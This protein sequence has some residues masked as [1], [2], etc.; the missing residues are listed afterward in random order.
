MESSEEKDLQMDGS[1]SVSDSTRQ[2]SL[3]EKGLAYQVSLCIDG[4]KSSRKAWQK[5][6]DYIAVKLSDISDA[7]LL[8]EL[9][10]TLTI[11]YDKFL[12]SFKKFESL[13]FDEK[14]LI[15]EE[16]QLV[17]E[18]Q[19][20]IEEKVKRKLLQLQNDDDDGESVKSEHSRVSR[21][22]ANSKESKMSLSKIMDA[23]RKVAKIK[24]EL[25]CYENFEK[26]LEHKKLMM[27]RELEKAEAEQT[28][29]ED[30]DLFDIKLEK[31]IGVA[32]ME[33][34]DS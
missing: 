24:N 4:Y 18:R 16:F 32:E 26:E 30:V 23:A 5:S 13:E 14:F 22:S 19:G 25:M 20:K 8:E 9:L 34:R 2:R 12:G 31:G 29:V 1:N 15:S 21:D 11:K 17:I 28:A 27:K 33:A 6:Y 10:E 7:P 3:T